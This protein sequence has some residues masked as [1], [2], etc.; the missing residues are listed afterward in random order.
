MLQPIPAAKQRPEDAREDSGRQSSPAPSAGPGRAATPQSSGKRPPA[1]CPDQTSRL[2]S[3]EPSS[4]SRAAARPSSAAPEKQAGKGSSAGGKGRRGVVEVDR[5]C[6][7]RSGGDA[8]VKLL[9]PM[10]Q[11][12]P[13][14]TVQ[15]AHKVASLQGGAL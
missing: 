11:P 10:K 2:A 14:N 4:D 9:Q 13:G 5:R 15:E 8:R 6:T 12:P 3:L 7:D 1:G